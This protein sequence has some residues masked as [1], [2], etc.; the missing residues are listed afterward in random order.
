MPRLLEI[1]RA[2]NFH[3]EFADHRLGL[4]EPLRMDVR[5]QVEASTVRCMTWS[6]RDDEEAA[7]ENY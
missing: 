7:S 4:G 5:E 6:D 2:V 3:H 1:G